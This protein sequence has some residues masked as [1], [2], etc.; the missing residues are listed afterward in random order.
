M[1]NVMQNNPMFWPL[2]V[3]CDGEGT[4]DDEKYRC[5]TY[6]KWMAM[7]SLN[8]D[9][10]SL[11]HLLNFGAFCI[12]LLTQPEAEQHMRGR[13]L[14]HNLPLRNFCT[15]KLRDTWRHMQSNLCMA[16]EEVL[17]LILKCLYC[18]LQVILIPVHSLF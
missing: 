18:F 7:G 16:E 13:I 1:L 14:P 4:S 12:G 2:E 5:A 17:F 9:S 6:L 11:L 3:H 8:I 15:S 10:V